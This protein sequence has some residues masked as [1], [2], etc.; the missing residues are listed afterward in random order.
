MQAWLYTWIWSNKAGDSAV[1]YRIN[2]KEK[3]IFYYI[4]WMIQ[5]NS[6]PIKWLSLY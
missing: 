3:Y 1:L 5:L 4:M 6:D 2:S